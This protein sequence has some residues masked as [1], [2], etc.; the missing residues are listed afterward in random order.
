MTSDEE[1]EHV[2]IWHF[3]MMNDTVRNTAYETALGSAL[4]NGGIVL[5]IGSGSGLLAMMA[6]RQGASRVITCEA[7]PMIARKAIEII[8]RNGLE[9][10]IQ[11]INKK[12]TD[13]VVGQDFPEHA[14]VLV[15][16]IFDDG[17]LGEFAFAAIGHAR[18]NLLKPG[19]QLIPT[20]VRVMAMAI[21]SKEIF[22]NHRVYQAAG[23]DVSA[24]NEFSS[25]GYYGYHLAKMAYKPMS[26][27][28]L[29]FEFD[30]KNL[31]GNEKIPFNL[32]AIDSGTCH[33]IAYWFQLKLDDSI[34]IS[35]M[36]GLPQ[37][38]CW[39]QAVQLMESPERLT[40]GN[41]LKLFAH[42]DSEA[43]WFSHNPV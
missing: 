37:L 42:H 34:T 17:L 36:P 25:V 41:T 38:S 6:I 13:L 9:D 30:F 35:T 3:P 4:K 28:K 2:D 10:R 11:V 14:D 24:F 12:S 33:A 32:E 8:R 20:G 40:K 39:K 19:A 16:E 15:T 21:E 26:A 31:P 22:Q 18:K 27:P 23:F 29:V 7:I 5:D 1:L 43:L